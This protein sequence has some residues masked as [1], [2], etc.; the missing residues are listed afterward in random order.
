M[1]EWEHL[2]YMK[3]LHH[4]SFPNAPPPP[5]MVFPVNI[6]WEVFRIHHHLFTSKQRILEVLVFITHW[7]GW[8]WLKF[9]TLKCIT[10]GSS[11]RGS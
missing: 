2:A 3:P 5:Q 7:Q 10:A 6:I 11:G 1:S 8:H 4:Q 9:E